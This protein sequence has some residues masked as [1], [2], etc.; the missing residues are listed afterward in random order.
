[1]SETVSR[2]LSAR[3]AAIAR[4]LADI[5]EET[6]SPES[7][8]PAAAAFLREWATTAANAANGD[9]AIPQPF[10]RLVERLGLGPGEADLIMLAGLS[11]EHEGLASTMRSL[12]PRGDAY[13][14]VGLGAH[15]V[16]HLLPDRAEI[17]R[18][19]H[20]GPAVR[21]GVLRVIGDGPF[22]DRSLMVADGLWSAL[23]GH[24]ALPRIIREVRLGAVPVGLDG[25]LELPAVR[26]AVAAM[27]S[28]QPRLL[29]VSADDE[30]IG[31]SRCLA[32]AAATDMPLIVGRAPA[33]DPNRVQLLV[34]HA[35]ARDAV[36]VLVADDRDAG[37]LPAVIDDADV[38][39]PL[40]VCAPPGTVRA[41]PATP[42]LPVPLG[43]LGTEDRRNAWRA[44]V[45]DAEDAA[46]LLA[47]R[48]PLDPA[49][50]AQ[51]GVDLRGRE[52][53]SDDSAVDA[54][55]VA[56]AIR[57][58]AVTIL[59][60]GVRLQSPHLG[61]NRLVLG[62]ESRALL[63]DAVRRLEH[64]SLVLDD[65]GI[66]ESARA[67]RGAR[68]LFTGPPGT[69]KSLAAEVVAS[70][71]GTDLL[72]V[73]V[74]Q[75]VSKWVGETEKNL[76]AVFD[77]AERTQAVLLL[78]EADALF[79]ARTEITDAHDRYANLETA[80]LL[81]RLD[82]F[83]GLVVLASNLRHNIDLAF[84]RRMDFLVEFDLP[85]ERERFALWDLHLPAHVRAGDVDLVAMADQY[86]IPG[87][88]IRN[89]A[90]AAA[91]L[92]AEE[93][94]QARQVRQAHLVTAVRREYAKSGRPFPGEPR[95]RL[96][97]DERA[98]AALAAASEQTTE[99]TT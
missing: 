79:G 85:A 12:N 32:L 74:S 41:G 51:V 4:R 7:G 73:D 62:G 54:E 98:L 16:Q 33:A 77:V 6:C 58:R 65:W 44:A 49:L 5:V 99:E 29:L 71:A 66:R 63:Q 31:L 45:P 83:D 43:P 34:L 95:D 35:L 80:F 25:W 97:A 3:A 38:R 52:G 11:E 37:G 53:L 26:N 8:A 40:L 24:A 78:D 13:P 59:P 23:H 68:M 60:A 61:W 22:F 91:F 42:V 50:T 64:Q 88:W 46:P 87:G 27:K 84:V 70:A 18:L 39:G 28:H 19:L 9:S 69:G 72:T 94:S 1:M 20:E 96:A 90:I 89:A 92:A 30:S 56:A 15:A 86:P 82:R 10:D 47:A 14:T 55:T 76:A 17:R 67:D 75:V 48:H 2:S 57:A 81:Q 21:T 36:P 93:V